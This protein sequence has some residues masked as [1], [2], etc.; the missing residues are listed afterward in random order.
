M[1][2]FDLL[3]L[4]TE[5]VSD[6]PLV[7]FRGG[8]PISGIIV[9]IIVMFMAT[10]AGVTGATTILPICLLLFDLELS[11]AVAHT[12]FFTFISTSSR[13]F[14]DMGR[15]PSTKEKKTINYQVVIITAPAIFLASYIGV[16]LERA[17]SPLMIVIAMTIVLSLS[18]YISSR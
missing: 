4:L 6:K 5:T 15:S 8:L 14:Y 3:R 7:N 17:S 10:L 16:E 9:L 13:V 1:K 2:I 11:E 18:T 12:A